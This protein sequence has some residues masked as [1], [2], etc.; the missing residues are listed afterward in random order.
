MIRYPTARRAVVAT[1]LLVLAGCRTTVLPPQRVESAA[2]VYLA[3]YDRFHTSLVV[4]GEGIATEFT[5][6]DLDLFARYDQSFWPAF[7][8]MGFP[9]Q[10]VLGRREVVW[11]G[12]D[13]EALR[14]LLDNQENCRRLSVFQVERAALTTLVADLEQSFE[15]ARSSAIHNEPLGLTFVDHPRSYHFLHNCNHQ[16]AEWLERLGCQVSCGRALARFEVLVSPEETQ[17][18]P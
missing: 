9:T 15:K 17:R 3:H 1:S 16:L 4:P 12:N 8:G 14:L 6:G 10:G 5:Y 11:E 2:P 18:A 7:K 13:L